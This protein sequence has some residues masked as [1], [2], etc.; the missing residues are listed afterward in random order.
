MILFVIRSGMYPTLMR[1]LRC[2][3]YNEC[4]ILIHHRVVQHVPGL[5]INTLRPRK[6]E[7]HFADDIFKCILLNKNVWIAIRNSLKF[8]PKGPVNN[9]PVLGQIMVWRR[10]GGRPL[11]EPIL[12][13]LPTYT[14]VTR[15]QWVK[16]YAGS[17]I[18][19]QW[20]GIYFIIRHSRNIAPLRF[21][22]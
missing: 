14:C 6:Y 17:T 22:Q 7:R 16:S 21:L 11:S 8:V 15:P 19:V 20:R 10:P 13:S 1:N 2:V 12:V 5:I 3:S 9:S 18:I 4:T